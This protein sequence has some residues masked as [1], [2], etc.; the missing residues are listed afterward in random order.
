MRTKTTIHFF[1]LVYVYKHIYID[2]YIHIYI[3][4]SLFFTG[5]YSLRVTVIIMAYQANLLRFNSASEREEMRDALY[6]SSSTLR[7][8][9]GGN[10]LSNGFGPV[11][12]VTGSPGSH[13]SSHQSSGSRQSPP[14]AIAPSIRQHP[15]PQGSPVRHDPYSDGDSSES[16]LREDVGGYP[17]SPS[18]CALR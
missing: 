12:P 1:V 6:L 4:P 9:S 8:P 18:P 10:S 11:P 14:I 15:S 3:S 2:T 17:F 5:K 16:E 13:K 7:M